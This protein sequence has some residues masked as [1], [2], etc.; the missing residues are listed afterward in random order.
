MSISSLGRC[1]DVDKPDFGCVVNV[2]TIFPHVNGLPP[3]L[4]CPSYS[5]DIMT[6]PGAQDA[7]KLRVSHSLGSVG[8]GLGK[9]KYLT[10]GTFLM[11]DTECGLSAPD[12]GGMQ[13]AA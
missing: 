7:G 9:C 12:P 10:A 11:M 8:P 13:I 3:P 2:V 4:I 1:R 5:A 6:R